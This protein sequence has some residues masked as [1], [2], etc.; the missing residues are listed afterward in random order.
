MPARE[1]ARLDVGPDAPA[2]RDAEHQGEVD[3]RVGEAPVFELRVHRRQ[4]AARG[5]AHR[6]LKLAC[7]VRRAEF[8]P[9]PQS[10]GEVNLTAGNL[11]I[12][13][14]ITG[15]YI[16]VRGLRIGSTGAQDDQRKSE[17]DRGNS[18][19]T[20]AELMHIGAVGRNSGY[21]QKRRIRRKRGS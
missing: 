7:E 10:S 6:K 9:P 18:P 16:Q 11:G 4:L 19:R 3:I 21:R 8:K 1:R 17:K 20:K 14:C 12:G 2:S 13:V 5:A 15:T